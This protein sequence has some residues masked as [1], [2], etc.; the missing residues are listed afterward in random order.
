[1]GRS[2]L[3]QPNCVGWILLDQ[4]LIARYSDSMLEASNDDQKAALG[5]MH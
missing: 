5:I 2:E 4:T 3:P 1:M